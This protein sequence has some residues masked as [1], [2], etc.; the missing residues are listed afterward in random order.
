MESINNNNN[1]NITYSANNVNQSSSYTTHS[2][3]VASFASSTSSS[4]HQTNNG[5]RNPYRA[6]PNRFKTNRKPFVSKKPLEQN[7]ELTVEEG[8]VIDSLLDETVRDKEKEPGAIEPEFKESSNG[9]LNDINMNIKQNVKD[10]RR[11]RHGQMKTSSY[12]LN[13]NEYGS[14]SYK[15]NNGGQR[16][17]GGGDF[18]KVRTFI[19]LKK[20]NNLRKIRLNKDNKI[21]FFVNSILDR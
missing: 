5:G 3:A 7:N 21:I 1:N 15:S 14:H 17:S 2:S 13:N 12:Q 18:K 9:N 20:K 6:N 19:K 11:Q 8:K 10:K 4:Q 16:N